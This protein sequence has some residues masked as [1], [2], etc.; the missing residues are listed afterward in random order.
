M[1]PKFDASKVVEILNEHL[2]AMETAMT[3]KKRAEYLGDL[4]EY[5]VRF[6]VL[7]RLSST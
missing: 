4:E 6:P 5:W 3:A 2:R 7:L 1:A